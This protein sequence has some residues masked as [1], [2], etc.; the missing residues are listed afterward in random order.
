MDGGRRGFLMMVYFIFDF[1]PVVGC[2]GSFVPS[3]STTT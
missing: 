3:T 1:A 2:G